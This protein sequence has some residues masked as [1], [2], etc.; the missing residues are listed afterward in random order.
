MIIR[1]Y[2]CT[3]CGK[4]WGSKAAAEEHICLGVNDD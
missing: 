2:A 3:N 1:L 4:D